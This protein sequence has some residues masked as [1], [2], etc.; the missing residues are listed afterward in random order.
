MNTQS[1]KIS[2]PWKD[3]IDYFLPLLGPHWKPLCLAL[4]AML[5]DAVFTVFRPWPLKIVID[6]VLSQKPTRVPFIRAWL[7]SASFSPLE[8]LYGACLAT[9]VIAVVTGLL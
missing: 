4:L 2:R 8:I 5:L 9:L 3:W 6:R 1:S 7:D